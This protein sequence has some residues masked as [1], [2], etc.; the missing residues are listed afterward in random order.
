[1]HVVDAPGGK[2]VA[3]HGG[4]STGD[5]KADV[6]ALLERAQAAGAI[7]TDQPHNR[8]WGIHSGYFRDPDGHLCEIICQLDSAASPA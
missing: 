7:V 3:D 6:D 5:S 1:V 8:P 2:E 4:A